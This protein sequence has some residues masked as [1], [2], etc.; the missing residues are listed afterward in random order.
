MR[1]KRLTILA[2]FVA[3]ALAAVGVTVAVNGAH[4][5]NDATQNA[6]N[7]GLHSAKL[8]F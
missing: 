5:G 1:S 3:L 6:N 8:G 4:A 2:G 7:N